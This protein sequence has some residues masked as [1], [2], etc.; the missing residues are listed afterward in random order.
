VGIRAKNIHLQKLQ[1]SAFERKNRAYQREPNVAAIRQ[2]YMLE[3]S[4]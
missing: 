1:P 4:A 3:A 2:S